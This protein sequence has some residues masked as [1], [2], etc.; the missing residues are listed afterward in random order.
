MQQKKIAIICSRLD[1][2]G[3]IERAICNTANLFVEK[4]NEVTLVI[5]DEHKGSFYPLHQKIKKEFLHL[6]FGI[7]EKGNTL[8][9]KLVFYR[10]VR[11][12]NKVLQEIDADFIVTTD[13]IFS[14]AVQ[15]NRKGLKAKVFSWEHHHIKW[16]QKSAFWNFL[17]HM[18]YPKLDGVICLNTK[19]QALFKA[20][21]CT[22]FVIPN[23]V[24]KGDMAAL[25]Q[26][27]LLT[28]GW[29]IR[30]KGIDLIPQIAAKVFAVHKDWR[31]TL[32]GDGEEY[33][34]LKVSIKSL[35]LD[36]Q[37][38]IKKPQTFDLSEEYKNASLYVMPSRFECFPMV[39]LEAMSFGVPCISFDC[40]AGP[41]E[42]ITNGE[43][44]LLI[45]PDNVEAMAAD[46][47]ALIEDEE[48]RKRFGKQ[49]Y[50]NIERFAPEHV[51]R[52]WQKL[53]E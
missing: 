22:T 46:I 9:R 44:G 25:D 24:S 48:K 29:L 45:E 18:L 42:I 6:H 4:G 41:A 52:L 11:S 43:D 28:I 10:D 40:P 15:I 5:V 13:Y 17:Q 26:R 38:I 31:W 23:F 49:A 12:L 16:L 37:F 39:L 50:K 19:E 35:Q 47:I 36:E 30:R 21:G 51:Y 7:T 1:S 32:I 27:N 14:I 53:L 8:T 2:P 34:T 20:K 33:K 3:G